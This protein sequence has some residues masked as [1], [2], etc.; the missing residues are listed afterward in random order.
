[1]AALD[2][3]STGLVY[4][5]VRVLFETTFFRLMR[6]ANVRERDSRAGALLNFLEASSSPL[7]PFFSSAVPFFI[8][9]LLLSRLEEDPLFR[10]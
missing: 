4:K 8:E 6:T 9:S 2:S 5:L 1:M 3:A 7:P 10:F